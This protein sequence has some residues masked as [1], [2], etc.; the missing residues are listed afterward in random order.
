MIKRFFSQ[1]WL[2]FKSQQ[3]AFQFEEFLCLEAGYPLI[4]M[5]F[6]CLLAS[7]S[8]QTMELTQWVVGNSFLLCVNT[9]IFELGNTF[10][11]K[12]YFGR[13]RSIIVAPVHHLSVVLQKG[14]FP[15]VTAVVTVGIGFI[16]GS[17]IFHV[18]LKGVSL[19]LLAVIIF[20]AMFAASGFGVL[21]SVFGLITDSM[22]F[23]LNLASYVLLIFCGA[24][25]SISQLPVLRQ[26][27]SMCL[28][29]TRTIRAANM[30]FGSPDNKELVVL[31]LGELVLGIIY[32]VLA[33]CIIGQIE[34]YARK[35]AT[36]EVF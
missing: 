32:F 3:A 1:A 4:T 18:D 34:R 33:A 30:L 7:Y 2:Y 8:F 19:G 23:V 5:L 28:P 10:S 24:N 25:F 15:A 27:F 36:L 20:V 22:H 11:G 14:F 29:M 12:R 35:A 13:I 21:L 17:M 16:I 9:C 31:L 6:Y 26:R